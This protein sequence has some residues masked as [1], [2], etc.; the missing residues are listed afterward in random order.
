MNSIQD[1]SMNIWKFQIHKYPRK[2]STAEIT[3]DTTCATFCNT[4]GLAEEEI[5]QL[6]RPTEQR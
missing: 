6:I 2:A 1:I 5:H 4:V 3:L